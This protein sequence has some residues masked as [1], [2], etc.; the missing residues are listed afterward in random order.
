MRED[1]LFVFAHETA[2]DPTHGLSH[3]GD[4]GT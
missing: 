3:R 2:I 4:F 1:V